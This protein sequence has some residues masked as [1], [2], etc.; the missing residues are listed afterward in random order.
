VSCLV[1]RIR[2]AG[3]HD[4]SVRP[5]FP[6]R[7]VVVGDPS[8]ETTDV[9]LSRAPSATECS[10]GSRGA[11]RGVGRAD[12]RPLTVL[13]L[14]TVVE[15]PPADTRFARDE[16]FGPSCSPT[17]RSQGRRCGERDPLPPGGILASLRRLLRDATAEFA[18]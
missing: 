11:R 3:R 1:Q 14:P 16:A 7:G 8:D 4:A 13:L 12:G 5:S 9:G 6:C 15:S 2:P 10:S 17:R 18:E